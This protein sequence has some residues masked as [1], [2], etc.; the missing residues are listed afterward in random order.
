VGSK[1]PD[2]SGVDQN[3]VSH[4]LS[5]TLGKPVV[6]YFYPKD[7]TPGCTKE[8]C[9][10][11]DVWK[12]YEA[13]GILLFG[14]S[15]GTPDSHKEFATKHTLPF[16]LIADTEKTWGNAFGVST[17]AGMYQRVSFLIGKDGKVTK[18]Y[19]NVD[20]GVHAADVLKDAS[21]PESSS[22]PASSTIP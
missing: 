1:A 13:A 17:M 11:R 7:Q 20:P 12:Q 8:A 19:D 4:K 10:F 5:E 18:V 9:A 16:P 3:G 21:G 15:N 2:V 22:S 14:V 6:V